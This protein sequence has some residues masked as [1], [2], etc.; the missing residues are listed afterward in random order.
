MR[1]RHGLGIPASG[2]LPLAVDV[3]ASE[4][5]L[6]AAAYGGRDL[7]RGRGGVRSRGPRGGRVARRPSSKQSIKIYSAP[8]STRSSSTTTSG[9]SSEDAASTGGLPPG[10]NW[11]R[12]QANTDSAIDGGGALSGQLS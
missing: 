8:S 5:T 1:H 9:S 11:S 4:L 6:G 12:S 7:G 3:V 10:P 2:L